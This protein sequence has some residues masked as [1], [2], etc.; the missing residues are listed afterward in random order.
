M[1][2][3]A[4]KKY[5]VWAREELIEKV[6]A[7]AVKYEIVK[8]K[9]LNPSLDSING[10]VLSESEKNERKALI[11][12]IN[13]DGYDQVMEEV[14]YTWF[15]RFIAIRF[16]EVNGYL[17]SHIRVFSN[18]NGE[19]RPQ[20]LSEAIHLEMPG[21]DM[22]K[23][24]AYKEDSNEDELFKYLLKVQCNALNE[25]LP[26]MFQ[27]LEDYTELLLPDYLLREGS[28]IETLVNDIPE[29]NFDISSDNGQIEII[30]WM[31]Q[32]Y[33]SAKHEEVVDPLHGKVVKKEEVPAAT[34]LFTTDW[35][36]RYLIDNSVGRYWIERNPESQL[37]KELTYFVTPKD[38]QIKYVDEKIAPQDVTVF[39]P[40]VG[41]GHFL[42]YA[43]EVL[44]KIYVEYGF[45][46]RD[47]ASE[48]IKNNIYGLDIDGRATQLAYFAVM[49]KARQYDR[50]FFTRGIQPQIYEIMESNNADKSSIDYFCGH[51]AVIKNDVEVLLDTLKDAKEYGSIL[52]MPE[53]DFEKIYER[54]AQVADEISMYNTYLLGAFKSIINSAY[55][56]SKR[57][58]VVATNPPYLNKYDSKL[59]QYVTSN[60]KDYSSDLFSIFIYRNFDFCKKGAYSA[61]MTPF[62]WMFIK[63]YEK[64]RNYIITNKDIV[65]LIQMEYSAFEEATV[66]IC[67][68]VL[69]NQH[70]GQNGIYFKLSDF[71]GGMEV[72]K[73][74]V[75]EALK[76]DNCA[77]VYEADERNFTK[78]PNSP[79]AYSV[80][81]KL[82]DVFSNAKSIADYGSTREGMATGS[83]DLF[84]RYWYEVS[85]DKFS[86]L[87]KNR[88]EA[89]K[90]GKK[91]FPYNKGGDFRKWYGNDEYV[92]NWEKDGFEIMNFKDEK[93]GRIRSHNYNLDY[94]FR[95]GITWTALSSGNFGC[96]YSEEGKLADSKGSMLYL[97]GDKNVMYFLG[98]MNSAVSS[99]IMGVTSQT[100]DFKP[101]R[102][103]EIPVLQD[104]IDEVEELV[105]TTVELS[106]DDWDSYETSWNFEAHPLVRLMSFP[107]E[108]RELDAKHHIVDMNYIKEAFTN[109]SNECYL[110]F[111]KLKENEEK[112]NRIFIEIYGLQEE[113]TAEVEEKNVT[114]RKADLQRDI[115]SF[116]SYAV[117]CMF[118]R[119]SLDFPGLAYAGGEWDA[120]KYTTFKP[121]EDAIIPIC[122]DE[123]FDDDIVGR[124]I[125]FVEIVYGKQT[126][127]ENLQFIADALG[128]KGSSREVIR[129]Y[130]VND[131]YADHVKI[132]QKKPIYW[133][134]DSGK[135]NGFKCLIYM[136]RYQSDTIARIRTDYVHEQQARYRTAIEEITNRIESA[137][138]SDK[139]KLTKKLNT[140][141]SQN[142]EIHAYE[143]KI[144]HLADQMISIDL[145]DGIKVNYAKFQD[146]LAK[147]K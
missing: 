22:E 29:D 128:G 122:D 130:F 57:Y 118:G 66:P 28:V 77:Y 123:Y 40:C 108:E 4:I 141:K 6:T 129:N 15:N 24:L 52:Q 21:L 92:V 131:F 134:F 86:F 36:V 94:I 31:Y 8:D 126:L 113:L 84:M 38:G 116:M 33:I 50:R 30:G 54:F 146:V 23:V 25:I 9:E 53:V 117:G 145:D 58:A 125:K 20:I 115:R 127:E 79:L 12:K 106:K 137:S 135:K 26:Q 90:S 83:N 11:K 59:K 19:F 121:D 63:T 101:G 13:E 89:K 43:F 60:Y 65:S 35:V 10:E 80:S 140:L 55:L 142:D 143:E 87:C 34:Q 81:G 2:K 110:R 99:Y 95:K 107:K 124:F 138:G 18:E 37:A 103:A 105:K 120:T 16:M 49:M 96:R 88:E 42:V 46:E 119:Y 104:R 74:K 69:A 76:S 112:L 78:I 27:K 71:R 111:Q 1:D 47:A 73:E 100:L 5:A 32:Y 72:Q 91:W 85:F 44:M 70:K 144:H 93:S 139:V 64:L 132:Y 114:V 133:L 39:D 51:D 45:S 67:A 68:F 82:L 41:S 136:H 7:R 147:I 56:M 14:A 61:L 109:W 75:L 17:P 102:V 3:N 98:L 97:A 62:V 48:I